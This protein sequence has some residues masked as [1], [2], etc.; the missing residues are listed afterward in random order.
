MAFAVGATSVGRLAAGKLG[1]SLFQI[2]ANDFASVETRAGISV[3]SDFVCGANEDGFHLTGVNFG[4][5]VPE[6]TEYAD[7]RNVMEGDADPE[8]PSATQPADRPFAARGT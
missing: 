2:G 1:G 3:S 7:L 6:P 4:R 8:V 5:D